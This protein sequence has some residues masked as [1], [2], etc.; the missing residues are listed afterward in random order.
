MPSPPAGESGAATL[1]HRSEK[2]RQMRLGWLAVTGAALLAGRANAG[3]DQAP[4]TA[5]SMELLG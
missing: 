1:D 5:V 2:E 3:D 4:R